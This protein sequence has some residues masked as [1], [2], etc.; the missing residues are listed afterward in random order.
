LFEKTKQW[1]SA[2]LFFS[3]TEKIVGK[4][5]TAAEQVGKELVIAYWRMAIF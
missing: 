1:V 3:I 2:F 5:S 4:A